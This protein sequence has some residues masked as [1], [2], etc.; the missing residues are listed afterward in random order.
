MKT[1][2]LKSGPPAHAD[3][4]LPVF[5]YQLRG[6]GT[7]GTAGGPDRAGSA[8]RCRPEGPD[9]GRAGPCGRC[10]ALGQRHSGGPM[11]ATA[12]RDRDA[13]GGDRRPGHCLA[14]WHSQLRPDA[15][16]GRDPG[17]RRRELRHRAA[18][19]VLLVSARASGN[20]AGLCRS[21]QFRD[22]FRLA[23]RAGAGRGAW[24]AQCAG[25]GGPAAD[26]RS[27]AVRDCGQ[28]QPQLPAQ[29][30][31][32]GLCPPAEAQRQLVADVLLRRQ[33]RRV[34]RPVLLPANLFP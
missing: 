12:D 13:A 17:R 31:H 21:W 1:A 32:G 29:E 16:V 2:F 33:F 27:S 25:T 6:L 15:D 5:R 8:S 4:L 7:A 19:G 30:E 10:L 9:G 14:R 24:L 26:S 18:D 20:G 23:V 22:G 11:A 28:E 34:C 3:F